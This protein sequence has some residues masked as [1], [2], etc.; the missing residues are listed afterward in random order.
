METDAALEETS[1]GGDSNEALAAA[2]L[3]AE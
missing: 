1:Y 3:I 2:K